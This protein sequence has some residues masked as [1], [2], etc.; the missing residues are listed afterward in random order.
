MLRLAG[1]GDG[2]RTDVFAEGEAG[3]P[4]PVGRTP[5]SF[6]PSSSGASRGGM[7][8]IDLRALVLRSVVPRLAENL[9]SRAGQ[10]SSAEQVSARRRAADVA[11]AAV[12]A[13]A[14]EGRERI[15]GE[16]VDALLR[17]DLALVCRSIEAVRACGRPLERI[18]LDLLAPAAA[19]VGRLVAGDGCS[20]AAG[21]LAFCNLQLVLRR[22][23]ADFYDE[24]GAPHQGARALLVSTRAA[25]GPSMFGLLLA[26]DF[27]RRA[28]WEAW[29][30]HSFR[31]ASFGET[32]HGQWF[33]LVEVLASDALAGEEHPDDDA[34]REVADGIRAIRRDGANRHVVVVACGLS[35]TSRPE[36]VEAGGADL[37]RSEPLSAL[38]HLDRISKR[39]LV[40]ERTLD[41]QT[42]KRRHLS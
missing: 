6:G 32:V 12:P 40:S 16:L 13:S 24:G 31:S 39:T 27:L 1:E 9:R 26:A 7:P 17:D 8:P 4:R 11:P 5:L 18:Y 35:F 33:D 10:E 23:A 37:G 38:P 22:Y 3:E 19:A 30:E 21:T 42:L 28:G 36:L 25:G 15:V 20:A 14:I 41:K 34:M 2:V 29:T